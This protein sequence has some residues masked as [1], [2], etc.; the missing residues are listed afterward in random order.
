MGIN[1]WTFCDN[2]QSCPLDIEL[3]CKDFSEFLFFFYKITVEFYCSVKHF[4]I[5]VTL[6]VYLF[7]C[8][9]FWCHFKESFTKSK[10]MKIYSYVFV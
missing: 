2:V 9:C 7:Y 10:V 5:Q 8:S 3:T 6:K 4:S 1:Y